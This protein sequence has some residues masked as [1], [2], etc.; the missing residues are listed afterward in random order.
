TVSG[1]LKVNSPPAASRAGRAQAATTGEARSD[2]PSSVANRARACSGAI[3]TVAA[4][5]ATA[6]IPAVR[7]I[8]G[9]MA[10]SQVGGLMPPTLGA[11]PGPGRRLRGGTRVH[12]RFDASS[13]RGQYGRAVRFP[14]VRGLSRGDVLLPVV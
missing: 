4:D 10:Y 1:S 14:A 6:A 8:D 7:A 3:R 11:A 9:F 13:H 5:A 2:A 12:P